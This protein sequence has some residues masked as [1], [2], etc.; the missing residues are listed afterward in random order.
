MRNLALGFLA[1]SSFVVGAATATYADSISDVVLARI[2]VEN[3][4][5]SSHQ[6]DLI[7]RYGQ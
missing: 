1:A 6:Q 4:T 3:G 5:A 7:D 2:A